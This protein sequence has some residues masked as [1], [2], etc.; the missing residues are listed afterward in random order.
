MLFLDSGF[1]RSFNAKSV[2]FISLLLS[3]IFP[4]VVKSQSNTG[5]SNGDLVYLSSDQKKVYK[6]DSY[7]DTTPTLILTSSVLLAE[8]KISPDGTKVAYRKAENST[9]LPGSCSETTRTFWALWVMDIDGKKNTRYLSLLDLLESPTLTANDCNTASY[10][11]SSFNWA[12]N[13]ES[14]F[15]TYSGIADSAIIQFSYPRDS[16]I[17]ATTFNRFSPI[18]VW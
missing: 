15:V 7:D 12:P 3:I 17:T 13:G 6:L 16:P 11:L 8:P 14:I 1:L 2:F 5:F 10:Q 4:T 18:E 9:T